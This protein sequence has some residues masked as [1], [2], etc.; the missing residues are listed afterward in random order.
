MPA[1]LEKRGPTRWL[2]GKS[3]AAPC[4]YRTGHRRRFTSGNFG[5]SGVVRCGTGRWRAP[6]YGG[7]D[8]SRRAQRGAS[9]RS[10]RRTP[11]LGPR[12]TKS[13]RSTLGRA[14]V[15]L[16]IMRPKNPKGA[17][18]GH[19]AMT[20]PPGEGTQ[21]S[22][23]G[24]VS[25]V[26]R[27]GAQALRE[28]KKPVRRGFRGRP[29]RSVPEGPNPTVI[30][31]RG[32]SQGS[33]GGPGGGGVVTVGPQFQGPSWGKTEAPELLAG[34]AESRNHPTRGAGRPRSGPAGWGGDGRGPCPPTKRGPRF[35]AVPGLRSF[36]V[37]GPTT[38][39]RETGL[40]QN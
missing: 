15:G 24:R 4:A 13:G 3:E 7:S 5:T 22:L 30:R 18:G 26:G 21:K 33:C 19:T 38:R 35:G 14:G 17:L 20:A 27:A 31:R 9:P 40:K 23:P 1:G 2:I 6:S 32:R 29:E 8:G 11:G 12:K 28:T 16:A 39:G 36:P 10:V 37:R 25:F 34:S